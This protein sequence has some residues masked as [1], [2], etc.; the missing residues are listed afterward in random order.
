MTAVALAVRSDCRLPLGVQVL[1]GANKEA[2]A[3]AHAAGLE[4]VRVEGF[5]FAHV[6]DEGIME[7][8]AGELLRFRKHIGAEKVQIWADIKKKHASHALTADVG[9][10]E[11]AG[12]AEFMRGCG[13]APIVMRRDRG[14]ARRAFRD[15]PARVC[16]LGCQ[17]D[18]RRSISTQLRRVDRRFVFQKRRPLGEPDRAG[19][20]DPFYGS[21]A[22]SS[23]EGDR[24]ARGSRRPGELTFFCRRRYGLR[25]RAS[26]PPKRGRSD[27]RL[28]AISSARG[29]PTSTTSCRARVT[30]V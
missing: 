18:E 30:P 20:S 10:G 24:V 28:T 14:R 4:F 29:C 8:C 11:T 3:V 13:Q 26:K 17:R 9:V 5:A 1:A 7:A 2:V 16:R 21:G 6:A 25:S 23:G 22:R 15:Q 12:A 19:S 27:C